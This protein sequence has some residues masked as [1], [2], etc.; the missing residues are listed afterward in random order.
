MLL[1]AVSS[2][3][4]IESPLRR[5]SS[6]R[7]LVVIGFGLLT[8]VSASAVTLGVNAIRRV[9]FLGGENTYD[10][11]RLYHSLDL[12]AASGSRLIVLGDSHA[13][14]LGALLEDLNAQYNISVKMHA[15]G[16]GVPG[17]NLAI[18]SEFK[19]KAFGLYVNSLSERD[20]IA[21][22]TNYQ[23]VKGAEVP[24]LTDEEKIIE[25][26]RAKGAS[27]ILFRPIPYFNG[28][29]PYRECYRAW[30]RP[31]IES[32][33][34]CSLSVERSLFDRQFEGVRKA[35]D[36]LASKV[37]ATVSIFDSFSVLCPSGKQFCSSSD[38]HGILYKDD[39]HISAYGARKMKDPMLSLL[40]NVESKVN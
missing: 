1:L 4:W 38:D 27:V 26:A 14:A 13:G 40:R 28:L 3:R 11:N 12:D 32:R 19:V 22:V 17:I 33:E 39:D 35:Q 31:F 18:P 37:P 7:K 2:H 15:R 10:D 9:I 34:N 5:L 16:R 24:D 25:L 20:S 8:V 29:L 23:G 6:A 36:S 21:L 30:F